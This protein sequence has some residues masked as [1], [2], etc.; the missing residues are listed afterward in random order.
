[1]LIWA[2][3]SG[4]FVIL[5]AVKELQ[6]Q[7]QC[8]LQNIPRCTRGRFSVF[9]ETISCFIQFESYLFQYRPYKKINIK[10]AD[11]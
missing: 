9:I 8:R 3:Q 1:M 4:D 10:R 5:N 6:M 11:F 7:V 2:L